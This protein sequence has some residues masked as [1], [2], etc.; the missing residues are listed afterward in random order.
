MTKIWHTLDANNIINAYI[1]GKSIK[2]LSG[3]FGT[4]RAIIN[5]VLIKH[6]ITLRS[7]AE[8]NR[9]IMSTRTPEQNRQNTAKAHEA[10][11]NHVHTI[12]EK[13]KRANTRMVKG[14]HVSPLELL[15]QVWLS[16]RGIN[17][18]AQFA[19]GPYNCDLATST[20]AV[21]IYGGGWHSGGRHAQRSPERF[22]HFFDSGWNVVIIWIDGRRYPLGV[23][24][25]DYIAAFCELARLNPS[26][27][28]E[29][30]M[31]RGDGQ[32]VAS[33]SNNPDDPAFIKSPRGGKVS[34]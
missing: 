18:T 11:R 32:L 23:A 27:R 17:T 24:A 19:I 28:S 26:M 21:E 13:T 3:E 15:V 1:S 2:Q 22:K 16:Q 25:A 31:I 12:E 7:L 34:G 30:R 10:A 14:L 5:T 8:A 33:G 9:L 4:T 20:V 6:N 29:Y